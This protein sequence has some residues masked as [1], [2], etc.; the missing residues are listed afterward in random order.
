MRD[1]YLG[2]IVDI[3]DPNCEFIKEFDKEIRKYGA[4]VYNYESNSYQYI[5][6]FNHIDCKKEVLPDFIKI[7]N[8]DP[9]LKGLNV[10]IHYEFDPENEED[11]E[12]LTIW[13][14]DISTIELPYYS[15]DEDGEVY[16]DKYI[17][18]STTPSKH[19][20]WFLS[21]KSYDYILDTDLLMLSPIIKNINIARE[22]IKKYAVHPF[23]N[24]YKEDKNYKEP[25]MSGV[26]KKDEP[27]KE[28]PKKDEES[29]EFEW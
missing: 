12:N 6:S 18:M 19:T 2:N 15:Y 16:E 17:P 3:T 28:S 10:T 27:K 5:R 4:I 7:E 24:Q 14:E 22:L 1:I 8:T 9:L 29:I 23:E 25:D 26:Y 13:R 20:V 21:E 11:E